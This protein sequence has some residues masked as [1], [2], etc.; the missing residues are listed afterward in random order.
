MVELI[1]GRGQVAHDGGVRAQVGAVLVHRADELAQHGRRGSALAARRAHLR[2][3][4]FEH[5]G[6]VVLVL[7]CGAVLVLW[8][9]AVLLCR[10][11]RIGCDPS[12]VDSRRRSRQHGQ[13]GTGPS[14]G[15]AP[16][17]ARLQTGQVGSAPHRPSPEDIANDCKRPDREECI[18]RNASEEEKEVAERWDR[19]ADLSEDLGGRHREAIRSRACV[20]LGPEPDA[21]GRVEDADDPALDVGWEMCTLPDGRGHRDCDHVAL[22]QRRR[23]NAL[24]HDQVALGERGAHG[25]PLHG[26][27]GRVRVLEADRQVEGDGTNEHHRNDREPDRLRGAP[28]RP[29]P[30]AL[31]SAHACRSLR[32][33]ASHGPPGLGL[34]RKL[35]PLLTEQVA[36]HDGLGA[37]AQ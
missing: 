27:D 22:A 17:R 28:K 4:L 12:P 34:R 1:G 33:R 36:L 13:R 16:I 25:V 8:C 3:E 11:W 32:V 21:V 30:R 5:L 15:C 2:Q 6:R 31:T 26:H 18:A 23:L 10:R 7:W 20:R 24:K 37:G 19:T 14:H 35:S 9:G 29:K